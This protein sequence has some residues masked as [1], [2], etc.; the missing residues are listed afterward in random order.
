MIIQIFIS[1]ILPISTVDIAPNEIHFTIKLG[2]QRLW[3]IYLDQRNIASKYQS[4]LFMA[5]I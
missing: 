4:T 3:W 5:S 1:S 2:Y